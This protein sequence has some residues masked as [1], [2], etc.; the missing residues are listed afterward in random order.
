MTAELE[1]YLDRGSNLMPADDNVPGIRTNYS[2]GREEIFHKSQNINGQLN[3]IEA[4]INEITDTLNETKRLESG[5]T[6]EISGLETVFNTYYDT[7]K[8]IETST[9]GNKNKLETIETTYNLLKY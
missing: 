3:A 6:K 9:Q 2:S 7:I 5:D 8:W 4:G 1:P